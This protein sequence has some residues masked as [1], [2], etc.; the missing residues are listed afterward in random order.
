[1]LESGGFV[2]GGL[3]G[4]PELDD[5]VK[6]M[7]RGFQLVKQP[8]G[9]DH[10]FPGGGAFANEAHH[11]P[12]AADGEIF[13]MHAHGIGGEDASNFFPALGNCQRVDH[14]QDY[15][16]ARAVDLVQRGAQLV[17]GGLAVLNRQFDPFPF[18][19][20]RDLADDGGNQ[21]AIG[22]GLPPISGRVRINFAPIR[23]ARATIFTR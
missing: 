2:H 11:M 19:D 15:T 21:A 5:H 6:V 20:G 23:L 4:R 16:H 14:V 7:A 22:R 17:D 3:L 1:M 13:V 8:F 9:L 18:E 12:L 10:A